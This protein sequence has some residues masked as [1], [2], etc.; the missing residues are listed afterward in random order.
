MDF[1]MA[2]QYDGN[3]Y[4]RFDDTN[5][6][7]EKQEYIDHI[8]VGTGGGGAGSIWGAGRS[9]QHLPCHIMV[10]T[11]GGG[12]G[13]MGGR[14][15]QAA[16]AVSHAIRCPLGCIRP[17][18]YATQPQQCLTGPIEVLVPAGAVPAPAVPLTSPALPRT[19]LHSTWSERAL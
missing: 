11:K 13:S 3:C 4:L 5:P 18:L 14:Q 6:E 7:A 1:G 2:A 19:V 15:E 16:P 9:R 12:A 8:M 17:L 10:G